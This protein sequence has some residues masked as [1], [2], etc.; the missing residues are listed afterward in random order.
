MRFGRGRAFSASRG[1]APE[2]KVSI[3]ALD[4]IQESLQTLLEAMARVDDGRM[5]GRVLVEGCELAE[6]FGARFFSLPHDCD[7]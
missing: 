5:C 4:F 2:G 7:V 6:C 1:Q 3:D